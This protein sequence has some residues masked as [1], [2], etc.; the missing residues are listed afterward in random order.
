MAGTK[1][2]VNQKFLLFLAVCVFSPS[3]F[4]FG[5]IDPVD[6]AAEYYFSHHDYKKSLGLWQESYKRNPLAFPNVLKL[7]DLQVLI[8]G[9]AV[10]R[11]T[12]LSHLSKHGSKVEPNHQTEI[13]TKLETMLTTFVSDEAQSAYLQ[14]QIKM[15]YQD[16]NGALALLNQAANLEKENILVLR[17]RAK[18]ELSLAL[19]EKH[20]LSL[21]SIV[22]LFPFDLNTLTELMEAHYFHQSPKEVVTLYRSV[23]STTNSF[24]QRMVYALALMDVGE[25][26]ESMSTL[27]G[28]SEQQKEFSKKNINLNPIV[29]YA[30]GKNQVNQK[31]FHSEGMAN[32]KHFLNSTSIPDGSQSKNWDPFRISEKVVEAQQILEKHKTLP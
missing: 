3:D 30:L 14:A 24:R 6:G 8:E 2:R 13:Q 28:M 21:K 31:E 22:D 10:A 20:Y 29:W 19:Y 26:S 11:N 12:L 25:T 5:A 1:T 4:S 32:L 9:R 23:P 18:C 16:W 15:Q 27:K 7:A 17:Q